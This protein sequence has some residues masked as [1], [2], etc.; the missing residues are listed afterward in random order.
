M[1][2]KVTFTLPSEVDRGTLVAAA[3]P[4]AKS[5]PKIDTNDPGATGCPVAKLAPFKTPPAE[6]EG[7]AYA[8]KPKVKV[9]RVRRKKDRILSIVERVSLRTNSQSEEFTNAKVSECPPASVSLPRLSLHLARPPNPPR[10][11]LRRAA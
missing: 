10:V 6:T 9:V 5:E 1:L 2:L 4:D 3:V 7:C 11:R 8:A